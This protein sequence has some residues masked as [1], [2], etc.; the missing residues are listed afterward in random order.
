MVLNERDKKLLKWIEDYKAITIKQAT[1]IIFDK[2]YVS[3]RRRLAQLEE[4]GLLKSSINKV[5]GEKIYYKDKLLKM[6]ELLVYDFVSKIYELG[7]EIY[8]LKT[9][10]EYL[11]GDIIPDAYVEV[12][13]NN[14]VYF[15]LLEVDYTHETNML[16]MQ[17]YERLYKTGELQKQCMDT[18]P[19][20]LISR[21]VE[22]IRYNSKNFPVI[23]TNL[24]FQN[25]ERLLFY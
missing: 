13:M 14:K 4:R 3:A 18:F 10:P 23:Y 12:V 1:N 20:I 5:N 17:E 24:E 22:S 19:R 9:T 2:T 25:V 6:H 16:K 8:T 21:P 7:G 15:I 11:G